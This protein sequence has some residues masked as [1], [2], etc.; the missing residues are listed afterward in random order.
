MLGRRFFDHL[1]LKIKFKPLQ[2]PLNLGVTRHH[3][4][5]FLEN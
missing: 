3:N 5:L 1:L 2:Y 4:Y